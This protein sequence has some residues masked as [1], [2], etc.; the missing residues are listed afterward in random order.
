MLLGRV[1]ALTLLFN[2]NLRKSSMTRLGSSGDHQGI[3][4]PGQPKHNQGQVSVFQ[5][6]ELRSA[7]ADDAKVPPRS[8]HHN[9]LEVE[10]TKE[11]FTRMDV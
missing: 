7:S 3:T 9:E 5:L 10:Y 1:Y 11:T 4:A 8:M 2:L 6:A